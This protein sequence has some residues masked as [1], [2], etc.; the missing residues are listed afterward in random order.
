M[1]GDRDDLRRYLESLRSVLDEAT[2]GMIPLVPPDMQSAYVD[3]WK[4]VQPAFAELLNVLEAPSVEPRLAAVGLT[5][6]QLALKVKGY[7]RA[8][9]DWRQHG[10]GLGVRWKKLLDWADTILDSLLPVIPGG[11]VIKEYK[12]C[13]RNE[14]DGPAST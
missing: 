7:F 8:L 1:P 14:A 3:A 5:G 10:G 2:S 9:D 6:K 12:E 4:E 13:L 11:E